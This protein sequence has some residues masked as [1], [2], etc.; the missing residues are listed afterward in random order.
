[1][2]YDD[3]WLSDV[4]LVA[5]NCN[6][7]HITPDH[8]PYY[9]FC[10]EMSPSQQ[11]ISLVF[12]MFSLANLCSFVSRLCPRHG[13]HVQGLDVALDQLHVPCDRQEQGGRLPSLWPL[14]G[15]PHPGGCPV[16]E[17]RQR[18]GPRPRP[19]QSRHLVD[20]EFNVGDLV[21]TGNW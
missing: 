3:V 18:D 14:Q 16:Q 4:M 1:M 10:R 13:D 19:K 17:P 8:P 7:V 5:I 12:P 20:G 21:F 2:S 6:N 15:L 11:N 9:I